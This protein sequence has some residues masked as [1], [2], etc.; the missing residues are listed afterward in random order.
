MHADDTLNI[1]AACL[2]AIS[3]PCRMLTRCR[4]AEHGL[5]EVILVTNM[6]ALTGS[7][8]RNRKISTLRFP[9]LWVTLVMQSSH[10]YKMKK[11]LFVKF[12]R[13]VSIFVYLE[14]HHIGRK[15]TVR[16]S[17]APSAWLGGGAGGGHCAARPSPLPFFCARWLRAVVRRSAAHIANGYA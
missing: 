14:T 15:K 13:N 10:S 17:E 5:Q 2:C 8:Y 1:M 3:E 9:P 12:S 7:S 16:G 4:S 11:Q 6:R